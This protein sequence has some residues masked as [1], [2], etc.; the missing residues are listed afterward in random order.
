[1]S[2]QLATYAMLG[3]ILAVGFGWYER[4]RPPAR[5]VALVAAMAALAV[6]GRLAFAPIPNVKPTTDIVL[7]AGYA[8]GGVPG[9][10]VGAITAVASN[11]FFGQGP[12]TEWQMVAWGGVGVGG[13]LLARVTRG[14]E[15]NRW[16]L[17]AAC[18]VAGAA[19]GAFMD[20][21]QWSFLGDQSA[22]GYGA[23]ATTSLPYNAAHVIGNIVFCLVLGPTFIRA[24]HRYRRRFEVRW[25]S[26]ARSQNT[27]LATVLA[28]VVAAIGGGALAAPSDASAATPAAKATRYLERVQNRD[29][30]F[31]AFKGGRSSQLFTGWSALGLAAAGTNPQ[32]VTTGGRSIIS[33]LRGAG[34]LS[35]IG[36]LERTILVLRASGLSPLGFD[37][38][39]LMSELSRARRGDG[40]WK[41]NVAFTAFGVLAQRAGGLGTGRVSRSAA[42]LAR[43][44]NRDGGFGYVPSASSDVDD[45]GA[46]LQA[47]AAAGRAGSSA[48]SRAVAYLRRS[49]G[50]DGGFGQSDGRTSNAQSTAW[51]VQ[52]LVAAGRRPEA[53]GANPLRYLARLQR[54][55]GHIRYSVG[56]DQTPVWV[57]AQ[58]LTALRKKPFPL[59]VEP[60]TK[61]RSQRSSSAPASAPAPASRAGAKRRAGRAAA[62]RKRD[63]AASR[64]VATTALAPPGPGLR[65][66]R[67]AL[68][69]ERTAARDRA[70]GGGD[71]VS[72]P[73][74]GAAIAAVLVALWLLRRRLRAGRL[75]SD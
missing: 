3:A 44:Q 57:T 33:Y 49:Q 23:V 26:S 17:A 73:L 9:F 64:P 34:P 4:R 72:A 36:E 20:V 61:P 13:A 48:S 71:G 15:L 7:F 22:R 10:A 53:M 24:L 5:V 54:G 59:A 14:R 29:G 31:A 2:W 16:Q 35:D 1:M 60:R 8:L 25:P 27:G 11:V 46:V 58:A 38:R 47:L 51:A 12:W 74:V 75:A 28:V 55:D 21:Y 41:G 19:F 70:A 62:A 65:A 63:R 52:G 32:D 30:G 43:A 6:V 45:T 67:D 68:R 69:S 40:S 56:S 66:G 42:Y 50:R 39:N 18:A 37:G